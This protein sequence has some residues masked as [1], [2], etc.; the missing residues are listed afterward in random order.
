[1]DVGGAP[2]VEFVRSRHPR[3]RLRW[4]GAMRCAYCTLLFWIPAF[5]GM[6]KEMVRRAHP[7]SSVQHVGRN[8]EA[9]CADPGARGA[10]Y[11]GFVRSHHPRVRLRSFGAMRCAYCTLLF[12]I[13][14]FAGMSKEMVRRAHPAG[15]VQHAGRNSEAYCADPGARGAPYSCARITRHALPSQCSRSERTSV[16]D[17]VS[18]SSPAG[19]AWWTISRQPK[20]VFL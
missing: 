18:S 17:W 20:G 19:E 2:Y 10:P 11:V 3:V 9:Y 4:F 12:W 15:S 13:P 1:M 16:S 6:T 14:A 7:P 8:S 5:A